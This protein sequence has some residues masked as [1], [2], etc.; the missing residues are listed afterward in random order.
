VEAT[1]LRLAHE[2]RSD[3]E[4]AA[5][6][7]SQG[8][9][10]ARGATVLASTVKTIRLRHRVLNRESQS[11]PRRIAGY[12]T[13]PQLAEKLNIARHW[14]SDRIHNGT[15]VVTKDPATQC[16]LFLDNLETL[17]QFRQL[18]VGEITEMGCR[19]EHQDA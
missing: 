16:Y 13:I 12:L 18:L 17:R 2:G 19:K 14:I 5:V 9:R 3:S 1:I 11:H 6:L 10:S 7:T 15:I 4:I 8:H